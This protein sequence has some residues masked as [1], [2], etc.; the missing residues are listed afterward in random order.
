MQKNTK[1]TASYWKIVHIFMIKLANTLC[2]NC[3]RLTLVGLHCA[4]SQLVRERGGR[5]RATFDLVMKDNW[6]RPTGVVSSGALDL[7]VSGWG[8]VAAYAVH[9]DVDEL[10]VGA[11]AGARQCDNGAA[12]PCEEKT[13]RRIWRFKVWKKI[14]SPYSTLTEIVWA[15]C[16]QC[17]QKIIYSTKVYKS[18]W[19]TARV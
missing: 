2:L 17:I 7:S 3:L 11:E 12:L 10:R 16:V 18:Q 5:L 13:P 1:N 15:D 8:H 4:Q 19:K 9:D 6:V 14:S